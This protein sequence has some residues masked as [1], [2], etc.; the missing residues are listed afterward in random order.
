M[1]FTGYSE[2]SI[3]AK[4]IKNTKHKAARFIFNIPLVRECDKR[5]EEL[6][7]GDWSFFYFRRSV[8]Q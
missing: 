3:D 6:T 2:H 8:G 7:C 4:T 1:L 5:R